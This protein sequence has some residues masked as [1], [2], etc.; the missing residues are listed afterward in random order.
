MGTKAELE[1]QVAKLVEELADAQGVIDTHVTTIQALEAQLALNDE[2][3][4]ILDAQEA[5]AES[6]IIKTVINRRCINCGNAGR[7]SYD[8]QAERFTCASCK[9]IWPLSQ[10]DSPHRKR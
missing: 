8:A 9:Y 7:V 4:A 6:E 3:L 2:R 10:E 5:A 1:A